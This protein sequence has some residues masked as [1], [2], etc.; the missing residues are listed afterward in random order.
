MAMVPLARLTTALTTTATFSETKM[1]DTEAVG[2]FIK[3]IR[4][5]FPTG[6]KTEEEERDWV[7]S[8]AYILRDYVSSELAMAAETIV[9]TRETRGFPLP[10]EC[11]KACSHARNL[12]RMRSSLATV[13]ALPAPKDREI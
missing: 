13:A 8:M 7:R 10:S 5:H 6:K 4:Q 3:V 2:K 9:N 1:A 12:I 11:L